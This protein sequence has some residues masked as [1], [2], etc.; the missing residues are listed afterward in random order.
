MKEPP[1]TI[2]PI[3]SKIQND[4]SSFRKEQQGTKLLEMEL[5][6]MVVQ[7]TRDVQAIRADRSRRL[8]LRSGTNDTNG[9]GGEP[10]DRVVST[11]SIDV[12]LENAGG[13]GASNGK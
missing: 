8:A 11:E 6:Q 13:S 4:L 1:D 7:A 9:L 12:L 2:I 3:L 5:I 10:S